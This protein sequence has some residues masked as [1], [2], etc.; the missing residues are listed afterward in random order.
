MASKHETLTQFGQRLVFA[1]MTLHQT[2]GLQ[3]QFDMI[4]TLVVRES[5]HRYWGILSENRWL[6]VVLTTLAQHW[7]HTG[8]QICICCINV[9]HA[10]VYDKYYYYSLLN[11]SWYQLTFLEIRV[12]LFLLN[13]RS[14]VYR[15]INDTTMGHFFRWN[16][17]CWWQQ[18][19]WHYHP[20]IFITWLSARCSNNYFIRDPLQSV[21][22]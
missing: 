9:I 11:L 13:M 17:L 22:R 2:K 3:F 19:S 1:G 21:Q 4:C 12:D 8:L 15:M 14:L 20:N 7:A 10:F 5:C 6:N 16:K 18:F